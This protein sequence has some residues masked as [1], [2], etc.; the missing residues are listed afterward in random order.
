M[1]KLLQFNQEALKSCLNGVR[2][3]A[4]A[5][6][7]TLGP[8]GRNVVI[9]KQMGVPLSTKDGVSVAKE[10]VLKDKFENMGAQLVKEASSK[11][12]DV[13]GDGTTTA[14]V[15]AESLLSHGVKYVTSGASPMDL[16]HGIDKAVACVV[17]EL[18]LLAKSVDAD[19][20]VFQ[21]ATIS[22]NN[23]P[24]IGALI[25]EAVKKVGKE[26]TITVQES[27]GIQT[28]LDVVEGMQFDKGYASP[29]FVTDAEKMSVE[30][31][32]PLVL[33]T[34]QKISSAKE[35]V[36]IL[37]AVHGAGK[38]LLI[39]AEDIDSDALTTLVLNKLKAGLHVCAVK[40]PG[41]GDKRKAILQDVAILCGATLISSEVGLSLEQAHMVHLG[42]FKKAKIS[43]DE[44]VLVDG[45]GDKQGIEDRCEHLRHQIK[46]SSSD[47]D[48]K[49]L[50]E[51]LAK[52]TGGVAVVHVGAAT[53]A[54]LKEKKARVEDALHATKA[55]VLEG[56]VPGGGVALIRASAALK[57]LKLE[58]DEHLGVDVVKRACF[59][60]A[61]HIAHNCG[62]M[63]ALVAEK[64]AEQTG[65]FG[66]NG[67]KDAYGDLL[68]Q[69]V[70]DPVLVTKTALKN[71]ASIA[72][73]LLT[74]ACMITDKPQPKVE[75][76][77][78]PGMD[79]MGGMG[80]YDGM[81]MM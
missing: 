51:R 46:T 57:K 43:K 34:D 75:A 31:D 63:G 48:R 3:M 77:A 44:T 5:V 7:V 70:I 68:A 36:P 47:Y 22:A 28:Y 13:T 19:N 53:E 15:L 24:D 25:A 66:Y 35:L 60:P 55:A 10:I 81:D 62:Q 78:M 1:A 71:A 14:I 39:I 79:G 73:L 16:K 23:D 72:G 58:G 80:G 65:S 37:E 12:N 50:E 20:E 8:K 67:L 26:G 9:F 56:I 29:Y 59:A 42:K 40:A 45:Q 11:T 61:T 30:L 18:D 64:I 6:T 17:E 38:P 4:K 27:K 41:F 2:T 21:V 76:P 49:G 74:I 32:N 69:G 52:M 54:E 33:I